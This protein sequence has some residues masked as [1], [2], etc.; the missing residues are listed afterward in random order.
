MAIDKRNTRPGVKLLIWL[1]IAAFVLSGVGIGAGSLVELFKSSGQSGTTQTLTGVDEVKQTYDPGVKTLKAV[2]ASNPTSYTALVNLGNLYVDYASQL[3][4]VSGSQPTT[5]TLQAQAELYTNAKDVYGKALEIKS[6]DPSVRGDYA[7][8]LFNT[9]ETDKALEVAGQTV[10]QFPQAAL[11]WLKLGDF[12]YI[13]FQQNPTSVQAATYRSDGIAAYKKYLAL[14][15]KG[16]YAQQAKD[17]IS[18][19]QGGSGGQSGTTGGQQQGGNA[20]TINL[21]PTK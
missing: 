7:I 8:T 21:Q 11:V 18:Q 14:E 15:P 16:Q 13:L 6:T 9:G 20:G 10:N 19:L 4:Q 12:N 1:L 17:S 5:S 2:V 3:S